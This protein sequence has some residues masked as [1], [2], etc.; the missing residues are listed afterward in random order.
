MALGVTPVGLSEDLGGRAVQERGEAW[1][2]PHPHMSLH[3][4]GSGV[5]ESVQTQ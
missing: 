3:R 5:G 2:S 4:M 1:A